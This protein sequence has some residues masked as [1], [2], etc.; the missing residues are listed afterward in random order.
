MA[1]FIPPTLSGIL[2]TSVPGGTDAL[3][4]SGDPAMSRSPTTDA[5][6][7]CGSIPRSWSARQGSPPSRSGA[8]AASFSGQIPKR[9]CVRSII[10]LAAVALR[11]A[12]YPAICL[13]CRPE[14]RIARP[15]NEPPR[16]FEAP[17]HHGAEK[18]CQTLKQRKWRSRHRTWRDRGQRDLCPGRRCCA[19][20]QAEE[21]SHGAAPVRSS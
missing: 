16:L 9:S 21:A 8:S 2:H 3:Q 1:L 11:A 4:A 10:V 6:G 20:G 18:W 15:S 7:M 14:P 12:G 19:A 5:G 13:E 17:L